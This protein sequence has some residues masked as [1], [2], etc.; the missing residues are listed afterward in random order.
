M[1]LAT[2]GAVVLNIIYYL[3]LF[4]IQLATLGAVFKKDLGAQQNNKQSRIPT[5]CRQQLQSM[6][7]F[8]DPSQ[9]CTFEIY[10]HA[11]VLLLAYLSWAIMILYEN[12]ITHPAISSKPST[13]SSPSTLG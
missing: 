8:L 11:I 6:G 9:R 7:S 5:T 13:M 12:D 1:R 4:D 10:D 2:L 3:I